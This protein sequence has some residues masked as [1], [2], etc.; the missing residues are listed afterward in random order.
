MIHQEPPNCVVDGIP[1]DILVTVQLFRDELED[2]INFFTRHIVGSIKFTT[3]ALSSP[4]Y[5]NML[6]KSESLRRILGLQQVQDVLGQIRDNVGIGKLTDLLCDPEED[7]ALFTAVSNLKST[8][9]SV[10]LANRFSRLVD[11][12]KALTSE[13]KVALRDAMAEES[14]RHR[15]E[16]KSPEYFTAE[17]LNRM[18]DFFDGTHSAHSARLHELTDDGDPVKVVNK[19]YDLLNSPASLEGQQVKHTNASGK[20]WY[21][22]ESSVRS[23]Q[24]YWLGAINAIAENNEKMYNIIYSATQTGYRTGTLAE[25]AFKKPDGT[26]IKVVDKEM[27]NILLRTLDEE[28]AAK[29]YGKSV[30]EVKKDIRARM[31]NDTA[32]TTVVCNTTE[33]F[34]RTVFNLFKTFKE[35][36]YAQHLIPRLIG[37]NNAM[38]SL[39][40]DKIFAHFMDIN[41]INVHIVYN[42]VDY[43][44]LLTMRSFD[45]AQHLRI[46]HEGAY[47]LTDA[48]Y[49]A[50][51]NIV[52][53]MQTYQNWANADT[54]FET[55]KLMPDFNSKTLD[56][57]RNL[58]AAVQNTI[59]YYKQINA[60]NLGYTDVLDEDEL[61]SSAVSPDNVHLTAVSEKQ[62]ELLTTAFT[63]DELDE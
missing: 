33:E 62:Y 38:D 47:A 36:A 2:T 30:T 18:K 17:L 16:I 58:T 53:K 10:M 24:R 56:A 27:R 21:T 13:E 22:T 35:E 19:I 50:I 55:T 14:Q 29:V 28:T 44:S 9:K 20:V 45:I 5:K 23:E 42:N 8:S 51:L 32:A 31:K 6:T 54:R 41:K 57:L 37:F 25:V 4:I 59:D 43:K 12:S 7:S 11:D 3:E 39:G 15:V 49:D 52:Q 46:W 34:A 48:T 26:L 63:L 40:T 60:K 1:A 61:I